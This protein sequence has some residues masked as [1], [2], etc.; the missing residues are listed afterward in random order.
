VRYD[1]YPTAG[2]YKTI[3]EAVN[4]A[5]SG[6][7]IKLRAGQT[8]TGP[9]NK[10]IPVNINLTFDTTDP[11]GT[12]TIDL[13]N[14]GRFILG[15]SGTTITV[16]KI[17]ICNGRVSADLAGAIGSNG[18]LEIYNCVFSGC[19]AGPGAGAIL[20]CT[21][22]TARIFGCVFNN[23]SSTDASGGAIKNAG[24]CM[25][26]NC[27]F[28]QNSAGVNGGAIYNEATGTVRAMYCSF[29]NNT[30]DYYGKAV[31]NYGGTV[32]VDFDWWNVD[33]DPSQQTNLLCNYGGTMTYSNWL[34]NL[35]VQI[36]N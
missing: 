28:S 15:A 36:I 10:N 31:Y 4:A 14:S 22:S 9:D 12:S 11:S 19:S 8:F 30:V 7:T 35:P 20:V 26:G 23:N 25:I 16:R 32:I 1:T 18:N 13:Q 3:S 21:G 33:S 34:H 6:D 2:N 29:I 5:A 27:T 17:K 24:T